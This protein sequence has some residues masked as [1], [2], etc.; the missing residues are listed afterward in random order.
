MGGLF[1]RR[2]YQRNP[3]SEKVGHILKITSKL[4]NSS[5]TVRKTKRVAEIVV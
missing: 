1:S 2:N 3:G 4:K 5:I